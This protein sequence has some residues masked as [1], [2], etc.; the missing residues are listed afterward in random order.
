[1]M[2]LTLIMI[3][4]SYRVSNHNRISTCNLLELILFGVRTT[5]EIHTD[6]GMLYGF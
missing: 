6:F 4:H 1:M 2:G 5:H 3:T